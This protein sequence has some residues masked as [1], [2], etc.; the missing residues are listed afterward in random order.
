M[1]AI[2]GGA[3]KEKVRMGKKKPKKAGKSQ[4]FA[5]LLKS[6]GKNKII[7]GTSEGDERA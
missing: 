5:G 1:N 4:K 7:G 2:T 6:F 3:E